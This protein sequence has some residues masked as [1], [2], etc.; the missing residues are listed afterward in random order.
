MTTDPLPIYDTRVVPPPL[1][2]IRLIEHT[3]TLQ[4]INLYE[5]SDFSGY[6]HG[7]QVLRSFRL[8]LDEIPR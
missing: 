3:E 7:Q 4:P 5:D 6:T 8:A 2:G 1:G